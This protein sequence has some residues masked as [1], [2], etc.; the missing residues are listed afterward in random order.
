MPLSLPGTNIHFIILCMHL[1][2][3]PSHHLP[4]YKLHH[5]AC[6]P[7]SGHRNENQHLRAGGCIQPDITVRTF[8]ML[9]DLQLC[10][11]AGQICIKVIKTTFKYVLENV[12]RFWDTLWLLTLLLHNYLGR[13]I[14]CLLTYIFLIATYFWQNK[15]DPD[16]W[17]FDLPLC[18]AYFS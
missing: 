16:V 13:N 15:D 5:T 18:Q 12:L 10:F 4:G 9:K 8:H 7:T 11:R 6:L 3:L 14:K 17:V 2:F 1:M